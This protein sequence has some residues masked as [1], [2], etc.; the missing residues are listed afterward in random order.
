MPAQRLGR[1]RSHHALGRG[2][3]RTTRTHRSAGT[4]SRSARRHPEPD[5]RTARSD[6]A[7]ARTAVS[8]AEPASGS[9]PPP[10]AP[11]APA[12]SPLRARSQR[13]L[14]RVA[15][16]C[17]DAGL[18]VSRDPSSKNEGDELADEGRRQERVERPLG[19][20]PCVSH[21]AR[22]RRRLPTCDAPTICCSASCIRCFRTPIRRSPATSTARGPRSGRSSRTRGSSP[23]PI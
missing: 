11:A 15:D 4:G 17:R 18:H 3:W 10:V 19:K 8:T 2:G 13:A 22:H 14:G 21:P 5:R 16:V 9:A 6:R 12:T 20:I 7:A 23:H 1:P